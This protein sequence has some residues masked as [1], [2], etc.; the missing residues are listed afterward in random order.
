MSTVLCITDCQ[1]AQVVAIIRVFTMV[2]TKLEVLTGDNLPECLKKIL[3]FCG[4]NTMLSLQNI[5]PQSIP[6]I[7]RFINENQL[8]RGITKSFDCCCSET[9][10]EQEKFHLLPGHKAVIIALPEIVKKHQEQ[11]RY[12]IPAYLPFILREFIQTAENNKDRNI[13]TYSEALKSFATFLFVKCGRSG[14]EFLSQNLPLPCTNTIREFAYLSLPS[15]LLSVAVAFTSAFYSIHTV[16][17][18]DKNKTRIVEGQ[19]RIQELSEYLDRM[20][21]PRCVWLSEDATAIVSKVKYDPK[22][23]QMVGL[24]LPLDGNSG[25]PMPF[26]FLATDS[27]SIEKY[28]GEPM[29]HS[30]YIVM[31]QPLDKK[32]PPF[33]LQM[34]GTTQRFKSTDIIKRWLHTKTELER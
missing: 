8:G 23:N 27:A 2:F 6:E 9:Y 25:C 22:T 4:Y 30:V 12:E 34:F 13:P 1:Y 3:I 31:A 7:E 24:L 28:L 26:S 18:I 19:L 15:M 5:S 33:V 11:S 16:K 17:N 20:K 10:S 14:Y 32:V 21:A 29:S